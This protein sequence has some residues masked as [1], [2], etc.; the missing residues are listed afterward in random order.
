VE[1]P[2]HP[3][4]DL[5]GDVIRCPEVLVI[6]HKR[7]CLVEFLSNFPREIVI[8]GIRRTKMFFLV[9]IR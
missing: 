8:K 9:A 7:Y 3:S 6:H 2:R 4:R 5:P 1:K